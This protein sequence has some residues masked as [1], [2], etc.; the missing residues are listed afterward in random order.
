M[1]FTCTWGKSWSLPGNHLRS[2]RRV[3]FRVGVRPEPGGFQRPRLFWL[4]SPAL[5]LHL[6]D[7]RGSLALLHSKLAEVAH[8]LK[9]TASQRSRS[10][11]REV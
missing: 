11:E 10:L 9:A 6:Q 4:R 7:R 3:C 1:S 5:V 2:C 8:A